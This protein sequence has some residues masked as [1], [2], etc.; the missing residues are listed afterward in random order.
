[1]ICVYQPFI[2]STRLDNTDPSG[3]F[4]STEKVNIVEFFIRKRKSTLFSLDDSDL[5]Q[6]QMCSATIP[7]S[8]KFKSINVIKD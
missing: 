6:A 2:Y 1:M 4:D 5:G 3:R 7:Y 8:T